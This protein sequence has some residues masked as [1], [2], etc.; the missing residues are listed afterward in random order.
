MSWLFVVLKTMKCINVAASRLHRATLWLDIVCISMSLQFNVVRLATLLL[1]TAQLIV[2]ITINRMCASATKDEAKQSINHYSN[3][4][5]IENFSI[6]MIYVLHTAF[7]DIAHCSTKF[8]G[9]RS[10]CTI[11]THTL[12]YVFLASCLSELVFWWTAKSLWIA[13]EWWKQQFTQHTMIF[14]YISY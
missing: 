13:S 5:N 9:M 4:F 7:T 12:F 8:C 1:H 11:L 3:W 14:V 6:I 2:L 10:L